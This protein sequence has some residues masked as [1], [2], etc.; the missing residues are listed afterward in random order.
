[1]TDWRPPHAYV[2]GSTPRHPDDL[3][4]R[5][6]GGL[7][8]FAPEAMHETPAWT[9]A[10]AFIAD[11]YFW[12]AHEVLEPVWMACPPN[13]PQ[14]LLVQAVIQH[15]NAC[16][17]AEMGAPKAAARLNA[18]A[19]RLAAEAFLRASG[20]VL[21]LSPQAWSSKTRNAL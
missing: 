3:F 2:P 19:D 4:D 20:P 12:E 15:A 11:G 6:K 14:R 17:K 13:A 5:F 7:S 16:L 8:A 9:A 18:E 10:W 1:M 21:G